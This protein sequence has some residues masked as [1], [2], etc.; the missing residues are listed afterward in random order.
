MQALFR[1]VK[2]EFEQGKTFD[3]QF[4]RSSKLYGLDTAGC[5]HETPRATPFFPVAYLE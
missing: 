3:H 2:R 4:L 5:S 1:K